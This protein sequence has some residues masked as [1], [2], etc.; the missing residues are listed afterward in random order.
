M[1]DVFAFASFACNLRDADGKTFRLVTR[2]PRRV[3]AID[4]NDAGDIIGAAKKLSEAGIMPGQ[5][6][7]MVE[8]L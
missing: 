7:L 4:S 2:F 8:K 5:E 6:M 1:R 3:F